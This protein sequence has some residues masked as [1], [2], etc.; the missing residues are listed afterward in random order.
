MKPLKFI[1]LFLIIILLS[2]P[3]LGG[4]Y[5]QPTIKQCLTDYSRRFTSIED[6]CFARAFNFITKDE[7]E[8]QWPQL[9][10]HESDRLVETQV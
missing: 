8:Q 6:Y 1:F 10:N 3:A 4:M 7:G 5:I 2:N 9:H